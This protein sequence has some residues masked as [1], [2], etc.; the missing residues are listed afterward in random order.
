M[1]MFPSC[2]LVLRRLCNPSRRTLFTLSDF[3]PWQPEVHTYHERKIFPYKQKQLY[4]VVA[5]VGSYPCFIPFCTKS[6]IIKPPPRKA[7]A[8]AKPA[9]FTMEAEL[10]VG[11]LAFQESYVSRVSCDPYESVKAVASSSTPLFKTLSTTWH[12]QPVPQNKPS[13]DQSMHQTLVTLDLAYAFTNPIHA[14]VSSTFFGQVSKLMVK[15]FEDRC[16]E[17]YGTI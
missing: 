11:F 2:C 8:D 16:R 17:I 7:V 14:K 1:I 5:D 15:A 3:S 10:T 6:R 12:F 4:D 9:P 13:S